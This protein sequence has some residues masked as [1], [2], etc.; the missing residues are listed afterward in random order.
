M[1]FP[2][3][4]LA[5][6]EALFHSMRFDDKPEQWDKAGSPLLTECLAA[7]GLLGEVRPPD[8]VNPLS[9]FDVEILFDPAR[10]DMLEDKLK[11]GLFLDLHQE[12]WLRAGVPRNLAPPLGS[13][14]DRLFKRHPIGWLFDAR[15]EYGDLRRWLAHMYR[16]AST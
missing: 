16:V 1:K 14:L 4:H 10:A 6:A 9:W 3:G 15:I 2:E 8:A 7:D 5:L 12:A 11:G 13:Y